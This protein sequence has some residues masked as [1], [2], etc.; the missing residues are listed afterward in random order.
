MIE[1]SAKIADNGHY[2]SFLKLGRH[3]YD[4]LSPKLLE[5]SV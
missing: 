2:P 3:D 4:G 1:A 5:S